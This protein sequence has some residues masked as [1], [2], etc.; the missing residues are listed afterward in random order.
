MKYGKDYNARMLTEFQQRI[1]IELIARELTSPSQYGRHGIYVDAEHPDVQEYARRIL[2]EPETE[3]GR[4]LA[5][6]SDAIHASFGALRLFIDAMSKSIIA[7]GAGADWRVGNHTLISQDHVVRVLGQVPPDHRLWIESTSR[8]THI[9]VQI[10][11][12]YVLPDE[13][14]RLTAHM[15]RGLNESNAIKT[16]S[17]ALKPFAEYGD[18]NRKFPRGVQITHGSSQAKRQLTMGDCY[19]AADA[20][21]AIEP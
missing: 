4:N 20:L 11:S 12:R 15:V 5:M 19:D 2:Y 8:E 16:L 21:K 3:R 13:A 6:R 14:M 9:L 10:G 18:K 17:D 1:A 7:G